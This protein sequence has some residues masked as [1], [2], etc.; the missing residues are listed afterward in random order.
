MRETSALTTSRLPKG[1]LRNIRRKNARGNFFAKTV[2]GLP[3]S[4]STPVE[5][6]DRFFTFLNRVARRSREPLGG[7]RP[8]PSGSSF[9]AALRLRLRGSKMVM[10]PPALLWCGMP[11]GPVRGVWAASAVALPSRLLPCIPAGMFEAKEACLC[12]ASQH[13]GTWHPS[14]GTQAAGGE[15]G[16]VLR[17]LP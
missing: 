9:P 4:R 5:R 12:G 15:H 17:W 14:C 6:K 1:R 13:S 16:D 11:P 3:F 7:P 10:L 8:A 2:K